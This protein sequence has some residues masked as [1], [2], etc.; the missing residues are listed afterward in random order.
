MVDYTFVFVQV[1]RAF[2]DV[3]KYRFQRFVDIG[4]CIQV[5]KVAA[6]ARKKVFHY[7]NLYPVHKINSTAPLLY[8]LGIHSSHFKLLEKR[9]KRIEQ[10]RL[11]RI[12]NNGCW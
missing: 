5:K 7:L 3:F 9:G 12:N 1:K 6:I 8:L 11:V 10:G 4:V 2:F